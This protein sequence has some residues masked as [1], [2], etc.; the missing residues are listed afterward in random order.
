MITILTIIVI[1]IYKKKNY[2]KY[3]DFK[4]KK[5]IKKYS[6]EKLDERDKSESLMNVL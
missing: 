1:I 3:L 6:L 5:G 2:I 4:K